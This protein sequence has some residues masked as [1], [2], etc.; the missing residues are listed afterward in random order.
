VAGAVTRAAADDDAPRVI[1]RGSDPI[2][3]ASAADGFYAQP[4]AV[5]ARSALAHLDPER[6]L[7]LHVIDGG[8]SEDDGHRLRR[9]LAVNRLT[10]HWHRPDRSAFAGVPLWGRVGV[11]VYD[12]LLMP[13]MLPPEVRQALWLDADT[14][15]IDDLAPLWDAGT[16]THTALA[17]PDPLVP[18]VSSRFGVAGYRALGLIPEAPYFNSGVM[19]MNLER[20]RLDQVSTRALDYVKAYGDAVAWWDQEGLN[21]V[22]A[23]SWGKL[24]ATWNWTLHPGAQPA[25]A[26]IVHFIGNLKPWRY[27][28]RH[29]FYAMY[30]DHLDRTAWK[31][32]RPA[33]NWRVAIMRA[34]EHSA[35]RR[36]L[37]PAE[38]I[39]TRCVMSMSRR[40]ASSDE[41]RRT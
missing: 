19:L 13:A 29:P 22:L 14:M 40:R 11:S 7:D 21:A 2:V 15:V 24:D 39:G 8:M 35:L 6:H 23:G 3:L 1:S 28:G 16:G 25:Q 20:W 27:H 38:Q 34:Y 37:Y 32:C 9:S 17:A 33:S 12:K 18:T 5:M 31:G 36:L 4:L 26:K 41:L 30:Y 10:V